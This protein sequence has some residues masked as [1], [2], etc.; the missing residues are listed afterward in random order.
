MTACPRCAEPLQP[1]DGRNFCTACGFDLRKP[2]SVG[3]VAPLPPKVVRLVA[4]PHCQASNAASRTV[5]GRCRSSLDPTVQPRP[6]ARPDTAPS[7]TAA[8]LEPES[9]RLLL[10]V[11][12]AAGLMTA[13]VLLTLL[14]ARGIG[15]E[16]Q[17]AGS[18]FAARASASLEV[19][20]VSASSTLPPAGQVTYAAANLL[21]GD[22]S[23]AWNEG[24]QGT[25]GEWV[26]LQLAQEARITG[27]L[28]WNGYQKAEQFTQNGRVQRLLIETGGRRFTVEL[29]NVRG[30][31]AVQL[32]QPV[33]ASTIRLTIDTVFPGDRYPDTALSE[34]QVFGQP[35]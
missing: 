35:V 30:S 11:T 6:P 10:V 13:V 3:T 21:D 2:A 22:P 25:A 12:L 15:I 31:Q 24:A 1:P 32:P 28:V 27:L 20:A 18:A 29:L 34:I 19:T 17:P 8:Q 7:A 4:C 26:Q 23:T 5:C 16:P 33:R 9:S 14:G